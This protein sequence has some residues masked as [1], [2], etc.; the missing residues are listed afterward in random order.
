MTKRDTEGETYTRVF[1]QKTPRPQTD[2]ERE[3]EYL[4]NNLHEMVPHLPE[5]ILAD[6]NDPDK[7]IVKRK[8]SFQTDH[9]YSRVPM[10]V[11]PDQSPK[12]STPNQKLLTEDFK[13][14]PSE[15]RE[16]NREDPEI[17]PEEGIHTHQPHQ[18]PQDHQDHQDPRHR[19]MGRPL[20]TENPLLVGRGWRQVVQ[21]RLKKKKERGNRK[22]MDMMKEE[23]RRNRKRTDTGVRR[24]RGGAD[25][26]K[27]EDPHQTPYQP[28]KQEGTRLL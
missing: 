5:I 7:Y 27:G 22:K 24:K 14:P 12:I 20:G 19:D 25:Q 9:P 4:S 17:D 3:A 28:E 10:E 8:F 2:D 6:I 15:N 18:D 16:L 21:R 11:V 23:K 13:T 1:E 26:K